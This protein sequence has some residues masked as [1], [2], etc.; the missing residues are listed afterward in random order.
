MISGVRWVAGCRTANKAQSE[1]VTR[2][3]L[4]RRPIANI[5]IYTFYTKGKFVY[6]AIH[7][8]YIDGQSEPGNAGSYA[9]CSNEPDFSIARAN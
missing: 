6:N 1:Q 4:S 2:S 3:R 7:T 9:F 5:E 8:G